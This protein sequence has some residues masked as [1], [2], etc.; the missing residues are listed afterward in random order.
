[1]AT[2]DEVEVT[3]TVPD[4]ETD[5]NNNGIADGIELGEAIEKADNAEELS[6]IADSKSELAVAVA[7]SSAS[8]AYATQERVD[9]QDG[10]IAAQ[11]AR[12][13]ELLTTVSA[14][15]DVTNNLAN[16]ALAEQETSTF[17]PLPADET[18]PNKHWLARPLFGSKA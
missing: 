16:V 18:P 7:D 13:E 2:E 3:V 4:T 14:L 6:E 17:E 12:I 10:I 15:V 11:N 1:M 5:A 8:V 9:V